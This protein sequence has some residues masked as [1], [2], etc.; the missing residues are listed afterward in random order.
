MKNIKKKKCKNCE[1]TGFI[2]LGEGI[3]G[4]KECPVCKGMGFIELNDYGV[5]KV[6][7]RFLNSEVKKRQMKNLRKNTL[8]NITVKCV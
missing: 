6:A 8:S 2:P 7:E 4:I 5:Q 1:G 3:K